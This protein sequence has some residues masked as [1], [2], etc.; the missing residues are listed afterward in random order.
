MTFLQT[1]Q[2]FQKDMPPK[3]IKLHLLFQN[4]PKAV[5]NGQMY[6]WITEIVNRKTQKSGDRKNKK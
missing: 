2:A 1:L 4:E 3:Q 5:R 6:E